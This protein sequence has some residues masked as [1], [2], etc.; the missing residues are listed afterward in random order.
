MFK[1]VNGE[2][3]HYFTI[4]RTNVINTYSYNTRSF[5]NDSLALPKCRSNQGLR[6]SFHSSKTRPWNCIDDNTNTDKGHP[7]TVFG[8]ISVRRSKYCLEFSVIWG[9]LKISGWPFLETNLSAYIMFIRW[10]DNAYSLTLAGN[11]PAPCCLFLTRVQ[12]AS[13]ERMIHE[14]WRICLLKTA[15]KNSA[16]KTHEISRYMSVK[17]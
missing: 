3:Q 14:G 10:P 9:R 11:L 16:G 15:L 7:T 6:G 5:F 4:Y 17:V 2:C 13:F 12:L 8:K 1:V